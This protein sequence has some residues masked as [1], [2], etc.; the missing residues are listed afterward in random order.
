MQSVLSYC[1]R[2]FFGL[3][4]ASATF[5][6]YHGIQ[7][8]LPCC[9]MLHTGTIAHMHTHLHTTINMHIHMAYI[10]HINATV[11]HVVRLY[12][13]TQGCQLK[14][15][16]YNADTLKLKKYHDYVNVQG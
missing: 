11:T 14:E 3:Q 12:S 15:S 16:Y 13:H 6:L 2:Q 8:S 7:H 10:H 9:L 5:S 4:D 1:I